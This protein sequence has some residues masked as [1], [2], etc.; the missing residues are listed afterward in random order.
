MPKPLSKTPY[1]FKKAHVYETLEDAK[2]DGA[3]DRLAQARLKAQKVAKDIKERLK[4]A[5]E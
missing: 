3:S 2:Y 1:P 4:D 5:E